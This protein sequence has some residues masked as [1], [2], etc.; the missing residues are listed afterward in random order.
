MDPT[1]PTTMIPL[2]NAM[3]LTPFAYQT[4]IEAL[5]HN[6]F[7][8][9]GVSTDPAPAIAQ[10]AAARGHPEPARRRVDAWL[11]SATLAA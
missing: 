1:V 10:P 4:V 11:A 2:L 6:I 7:A 9:F 8:K 5:A 3:P